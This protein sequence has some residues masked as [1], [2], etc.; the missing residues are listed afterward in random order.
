MMF[1]RLALS[2]L[3]LAAGFAAS[4]AFAADP[5]QIADSLVAAMTADGNAQVSY[6]D[7]T[8]DGDDVTI[9]NL[10]ISGEGDSATVPSVEITK[11][12][13][14]DKGGFT[15]DSLALDN[16]TLTTSDGSTITW[17]ETSVENVTVP[18]PEEIKAEAGRFCPSAHSPSAA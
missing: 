13:P 16:G 11:A 14:R 9:T 17:Q 18:S 12:T 1:P 2:G 7:A 15:A 4:S 6:D 8:A 5:K 3:V 10:K